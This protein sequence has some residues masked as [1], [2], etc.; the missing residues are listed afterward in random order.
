MLQT[1][2]K[3]GPV[4]GFKSILSSA[5][6][7]SHL[8]LQFFQLLCFTQQLLSVFCKKQLEFVMYSLLFNQQPLQ[9]IL[10]FCILFL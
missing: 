10:G 9:F 5:S 4:T 7:L 6:K 1:E 3:H 2:L 8:H